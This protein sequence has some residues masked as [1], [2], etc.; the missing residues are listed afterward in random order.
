MAEKS[1]DQSIKEKLRQAL[2]STVRAISDDFVVNYNLD[3]NKNIKKPDYFN[4][5]N[6]NSKSDFIKA[7]AEADSSAL[8]IKFSDEKIYKKN[9]PLNSSCKSLYS[10]AEK[11]RYESLGSKMLIGIEAKMDFH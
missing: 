2:A 5:E 7:R 3:K 9:M 10:I 1:K 6:L 11:I 4:L 8:K